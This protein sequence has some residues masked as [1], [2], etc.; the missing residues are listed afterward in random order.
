MCS[1]VISVNLPYWHPTFGVVPNCYVTPCAFMICNARPHR[2]LINIFVSMSIRVTQSHL[3][4][5]DRSP[6]FG[7]GM[8]WLLCHSSKSVSSHQYLL[9]KFRRWVTMSVLSAL[10]TFGGTLFYPGA[11]LFTNFVTS[12]FSSSHE[13]G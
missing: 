12:S 8:I 3:L 11:L 13:M 9:N 10:K 4:G 2:I 6:L 5:L 1:K 7:T